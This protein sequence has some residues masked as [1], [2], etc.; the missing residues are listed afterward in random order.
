MP[1]DIHVMM[2][3]GTLLH[4][5][6]FANPCA[7]LFFNH[8]PNKLIL[9]C[10]DGVFIFDVSTQ[11]TLP[12][13]STPHGAWYNPHALALSDDAVLVAGNWYYP[14]SVC[15]YDTVSRARLWIHDTIDSVSS[16][17]LF[18]ASVL[19]SVYYSL[20]LVL[21]F[22]TGA[23]IAEL[24]KTDGHIFGLGVVEGLCFFLS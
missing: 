18:G 13:S 24:L 19:A 23:H 1:T 21:D 7:A 15:G 10:S 11:S 8:S 14:Y 22:K 6:E 4:D 9:A 16:V 5:K 12:F 20:T 2:H 17:C 3:T